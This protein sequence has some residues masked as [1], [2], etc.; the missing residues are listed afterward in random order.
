MIV[1]L[2]KLQQVRD[3]PWIGLALQTAASGDRYNSEMYIKKSA[4]H[5]R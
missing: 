1:W 2:Y 5:L 3:R 4:A